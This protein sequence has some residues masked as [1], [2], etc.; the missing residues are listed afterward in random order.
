MSGTRN[1]VNNAPANAFRGCIDFHGHH[2]AKGGWYFS[3]WLS[4]PW[5]SGQPPTAATALF[6]DHQLIA[7][8][9]ISFYPR[10]DVSGQGIGF[11]AFCEAGVATREGFLALLIEDAGV[12]YP[13]YPAEGLQPRHD[14]DLPLSLKDP[15]IDVGQEALPRQIATQLSDVETRPSIT[16]CIDFHGYHTAAQ[17]WL[18]WGWMAR[19][20]DD[21]QIP[22]QVR[23]SFDQGEV[24]APAVVVHYQR[25]DLRGDALGIA[26]FVPGEPLSPGSVRAVSFM[27]GDLQVALSPAPEAVRVRDPD[28]GPRFRQAIATAWPCE[29][30][31]Y[32]SRLAGRQPYRGEDT[33]PS[34]APAVFLEIDEAMRAGPDGLILMGWYLAREGEVT[35]I[36]VRC[37]ARDTEL[38]LDQSVRLLRPDVIDGHARHGFTDPRSGFIAFA[39]GS[40]EAEGKIYLEIRTKDEEAVYRHIPAPRLSGLPAIQ[41]VLA[42]VDLRYADLARGFDQVLGPAIEGLNQRR[43]LT[44]PSWDVVDHGESAPRPK[45]SMIVPLYGRLDFVEYQLAFFSLNPGFS[46]T[47]IIYVLDDPSARKEALGMFASAFARFRVPFKA[48]LLDRN[49]GYAPANNIG[50]SLARGGFVAFVNSDVFP[51][52]PEWLP[53]LVARLEADPS[54]GVIGPML[55]FED[56]SVQHRGISFSRLPEF[57][58][59]HFPI[60]RGKGRR[61]DAA[62]A[63]ETHD[64]ITG[65]CMV[66]RH[67][68]IEALGG[69][70]EAFA[71]G[72]FEDTDVCL[73]LQAQGLRCVVDPSAWLYHL[74]RKSQVSAAQTWRMNL[75]AYNAWQH[76]RRWGETL[77][78]RPRA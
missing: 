75:T 17:G 26:I 61:P 68:V 69:F 65:A 41:R 18:L 28:L 36:R 6:A 66:M 37:G 59:W 43:L 67:A 35:S 15:L 32:L 10:L 2:S 8:E 19:G 29:A 14:H 54:I 5:P 11:A 76:E 30:R 25:G 78:A 52:T 13:I 9:K 50:L 49:V 56:G 44:K 71:V 64:A 55:L 74:E 77:A 60:H 48:V 51:G 24:D 58:S 45:I 72:D 42:E 57:S 22:D 20:L 33:L 1:D 46:E 12:P 16:G 47:E 34:L 3:G 7:C 62:T 70:D 73:K 63:L 27:A 4:H 31:D 40:I 23:I 38:R 39:P 53:R 21:D